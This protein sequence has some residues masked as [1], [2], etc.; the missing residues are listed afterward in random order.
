MTRQDAI[1]KETEI[2]YEKYSNEMRRMTLD[3]DTMGYTINAA[4]IMLEK[5]DKEL[6]AS[7]KSIKNPSSSEDKNHKESKKNRD[8]L[9]K[10]YSKMKFAA[11]DM[12][13]IFDDYIEYFFIHQFTDENGKY[14]EVESDKNLFNSGIVAKF[15]KILIDRCL[16][17]DQNGQL[18]L[19]YMLSL[20]GSGIYE[21][22][23]FNKVMIKR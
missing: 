3:M 9:Q 2:Q 17:N 16:D 7:Y 21:E 14:N 12:R 15:I 18:I 19:D 8:R 11:M 10:A 4:A 5:L 6:E 22:R 20:K 1:R 13:N 23:D